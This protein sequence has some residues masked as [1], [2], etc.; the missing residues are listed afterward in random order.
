MDIDDGAMLA[1]IL[2][3]NPGTS[4]NG[5]DSNGRTPLEIAVMMNDARIFEMLLTDPRTK[6]GAQTPCG[7]SVLHQACFVKFL[8]CVKLFTSDR[9]CT[10]DVLNMKTLEGNTGLMVAVYFGSLECV[11]Y[12][13]EL[14]GI[15]LGP[16]D[17]GQ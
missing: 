15:D 16:K 2:D 13:V 17:M 6:L 8:E 5:R 4:I 10:P 9:R 7:E 3:K 1:D 14:P 11:R 12:L